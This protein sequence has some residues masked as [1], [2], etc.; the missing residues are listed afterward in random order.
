MISAIELNKAFGH[1]I[2]YEDFHRYIDITTGEQ[3]VSVTTEKKKYLHPFDPEMVKHSARKQGVDPIWLQQQ[4]D[5][6][7]RIG[8][9]RGTLLH[10]YC[11]NLAFRKVSKIDMNVFP[12]MENLVNQIHNFFDDYSHWTTLAV[13]CI[14]GDE[15][16]A[17]QF[18][19]L[20]DDNGKT[21]LVD[22][23]FQKTFKEAYKGQRMINGYEQY[24]Q[25]TLHEFGYQMGKYKSILEKRG[26]K[27]DGLKL[28]HFNYEDTNYKIYDAPQ[29]KII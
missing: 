22:Y 13:E 1:I 8:R 21:Y 7:G 29:I 17:G 18:D 4:W 14:I 27:I 10:N 6:A 12:H 16:N 28:V 19:R 2:F 11:Q 9:E 3:L 20:V 5:E 25:D 26:F 23:K 15:V 24:P